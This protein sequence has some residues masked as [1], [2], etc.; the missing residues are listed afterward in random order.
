M[1][2]FY[3]LVAAALLLPASALAEGINV[4]GAT[5]LFA[6][7]LGEYG[8]TDATACRPSIAVCGD[9]LVLDLANGSTPKAIDPLTGNEIGDIT[10]GDADA[11]GCVASDCAGNMLICNYSESGSTFK[12]WKTASIETAPVEYIT[13]THA[14][15]LNLGTRL[16]VQGDLN[17]NAVIIATLDGA[18]AKN[19]Y[20]WTVT[21]GTVGE[22]EKVDVDIIPEWGAFQ[23]NTK[24]ISRTEN[25]TDGY[26]LGFYNGGANEFFYIDGTTNTAANYVK[27]GSEY[28]GNYNLNTADTRA[29]KGK[30]Y[31]A[32]LEL[33]YFAC[34][35]INSV[36]YIYDTTDPTTLTGDIEDC[37]I[38]RYDMPMF[39]DEITPCD[40][41]NSSL[42]TGD[43][44][45]FGTDDYLLAYFTSNCDVALTGYAFP[46][47][48]SDGVEAVAAKGFR[49]Y[50]AKGA[51]VVENNGATVEVY[52]AAGA[53]VART[54]N[55]EIN[56]APGLYIV[57]VAGNTQKVL[58]K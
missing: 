2:K 35:G 14:T 56:V 27:D 39:S 25:A 55:S 54:N 8:L 19:F 41:Y 13:L 37:K 18:Y 7:G 12:I 42:T 52:N 17:S 57:K 46:A 30:N 24:V 58:V 33:C 43:V 51:I 44:L 26:Y 47:D 4:A 50:G 40:V 36:V 45:L 48:K 16:H 23:N 32:I 5:Q 22:A 28:S 11:S 31:T 53:A 6:K 38:A 20:R 34:W 3:S 10:L 1:K 21:N 49:A 9:K 15:N 29:Y